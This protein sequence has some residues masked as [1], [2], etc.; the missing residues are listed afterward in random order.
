[1]FDLLTMLILHYWFLQ[2]KSVYFRT[3]LVSPVAHLGSRYKEGPELFRSMYVY[4]TM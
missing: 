2:S 4:C 1:M 3:G